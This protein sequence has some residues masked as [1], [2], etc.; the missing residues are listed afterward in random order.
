MIVVYLYNSRGK[1]EEISLEDVNVGKLRD[2]RLLWISILKRDRA[3]LNSVIEALALKDV[4]VWS[5]LNDDERPKLD[6]FETFYR[7]FIVSVRRNGME[8]LDTV[9]IDFIV[10]KNFVVT[11]SDG[12]VDYF[13]KYRDREKGE[14]KLGSLDAESFVAALL[15]LHI[16]SYFRALEEIEEKVDEIDEKILRAKVDDRRFLAEMVRLRRRVSL[17][18]RLFLPHRDLF[19]GLAQPDFLQ[20]VGPESTEH[21]R[22]L[23]GHFENAVDS[24]ESSRDTVLSLFD[25]Y[26]TKS[27]QAINAIAHRLTFLMMVIGFMSVVTGAFGMNFEVG[28]FSYGNGFWLTVGGLALVAGSVTLLA[29]YKRWI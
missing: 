24:I 19:Y 1:D 20:L 2:D 17:L 5:V 8:K 16:V 7:F 22:L 28:I 10:G 15:D 25:L 6:I 27:A 21:F 4:P 18:R 9:P 14:T 12:E 11:V 13:S 3:S 23:N 26:T 29:K